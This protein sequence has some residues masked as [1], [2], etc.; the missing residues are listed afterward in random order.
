MEFE[1]TS[2][3]ESDVDFCLVTGL[4]APVQVLSKEKRRRGQRPV[5]MM[6]SDSIVADS[7]SRSLSIQSHVWSHFMRWFRSSPVAVC[8]VLDTDFGIFVFP[9]VLNL[10]LAFSLIR[11][12]QDISIHLAAS[13]DH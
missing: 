11:C 6:R 1:P 5:Y 3:L 13:G 8:V 2:L 10:F 7:A 12:W 9:G 4:M